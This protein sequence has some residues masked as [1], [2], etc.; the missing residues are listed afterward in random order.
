MKSTD[1]IRDLQRQIEEE[2]RKIANCKHIWGKTFY[3]PETV[4]E[5]YGLHY[6]GCGSDPYMEY[7]GYHDVEKPRWTRKC[8]ECG[9][10]EHTNKQ[11]PIVV[12]NEPDFGK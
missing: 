5:G 6:V 8:S 10:E 1:K 2:Q 9:E 7:T 4:R 3:N 12:G 11:K